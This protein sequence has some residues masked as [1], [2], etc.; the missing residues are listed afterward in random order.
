MRLLIGSILLLSLSLVTYAATDLRWE[1]C[2][3]QAHEGDIRACLAGV[4]KQSALA[5]SKELALATMSPDGKHA[6]M[7]QQSQAAFQHY[8]ETECAAEGDTM[9][10]GTLDSDQTALCMIDKD[11]S[12]VA[13]LQNDIELADH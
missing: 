13:E 7:L 3:N 2:L 5:V 6:A 12:R 4:L 11:H 1:H 10:G 9:R 8:V